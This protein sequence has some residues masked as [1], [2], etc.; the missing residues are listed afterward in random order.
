MSMVEMNVNLPFA[1]S[2]IK[3]ESIVLS[4]EQNASIVNVFSGQDTVI[5]L[6]TGHGKNINCLFLKLYLGVPNFP[7]KQ[8]PSIKMWYS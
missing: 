4:K 3:R 7:M 1:L 8:D 2:K 5:C 6:P